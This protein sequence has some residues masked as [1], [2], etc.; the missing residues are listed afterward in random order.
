MQPPSLSKRRLLPRVRLL[1]LLLL[2]LALGLAFYIVWNGW[3]PGVQEL[4]RSRDLRVRSGWDPD[5]V[6][7]QFPFV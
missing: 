1:P 5:T 2:A 4:S 3:H 6:V 7:P